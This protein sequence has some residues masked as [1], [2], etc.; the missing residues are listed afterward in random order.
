M[1]HWRTLHLFDDKKFYK[2]V[3]PE[4]KGETGDLTQS[5]LEFLKHYT[6]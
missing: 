1:G 2:D 5:C 4:L 6:T 3:V